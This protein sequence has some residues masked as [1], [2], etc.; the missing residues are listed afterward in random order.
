MSY[1]DGMI[2]AVPT[3]SKAAYLEHAR[4]T[5]AIFKEYGAMA[6]VENWGVDIPDGQ[7]TDLKKAVQA[8]ADETIVLSWITWPDKAA[9]DTGWGQIMQDARMQAQE[10]PFDGKRMIFGAFET[11]LTV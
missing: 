6:C 7:V 2:A 10:M 1:I 8:N 3:A 5:G 9:R 11:I 4:I